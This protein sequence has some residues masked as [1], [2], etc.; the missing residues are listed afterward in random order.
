M[1]AEDVFLQ[2]FVLSAAFGLICNMDTGL[3]PYGMLDDITKGGTLSEGIWQEICMV[4]AV[5]GR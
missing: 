5:V 1:L 4:I 2:C 3:V